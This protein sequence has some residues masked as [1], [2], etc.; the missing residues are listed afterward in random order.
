M[1]AT[2]S[3]ET[4]ELLDR[5]E[6]AVERS[7]ELREQSARGIADAVRGNEPILGNCARTAQKKKTP[8]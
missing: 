8:A 5:A 7:I 6:R 1:S 4:Q 2:F 3:C